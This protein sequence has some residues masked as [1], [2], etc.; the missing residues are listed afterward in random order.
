MKDKKGVKMLLIEDD[1]SHAELI[2]RELKRVDL[3]SQSIRHEPSGEGGLECLQRE[4][5][6][7]VLLDYSL[8]RMNGLEVL[9]K[10]KGMD[11]DIPV[12]IVT[13]QGN[14]KLAVEAMKLGATDYVIKSD[15]Y[16]VALPLLVEKTLKKYQTDKAYRNLESIYQ[17]IV[18]NSIDAIILTDESGV[19]TFYSKG[20]TEIFGYSS[21]KMVGAPIVDHFV[22][23][24]EGKKVWE[25]VIKSPEGRIHDFEVSFSA[26]GGSEILVSL[27]VVL[28]HDAKGF[29]TGTLVIGRDITERKRYEEEL[30]KKVD[31][32]EKWH[33]L[34]IDREVRMT[35]LK[36]KVQ[37]LESKLKPMEKNQTVQ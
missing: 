27:S 21:R 17:T 24:E 20:A 29:I 26:K 23:N 34:T 7:L 13:G 19:I 8:P 2:M 25:M 4:D 22:D 9:R 31:E 33:R 15:N 16:L 12:I 3:C 6:D 10:M 14:E 28:L 5:I 32:L 30:K 1:L 11:Y 35:Q 18:E 37:E 36:K